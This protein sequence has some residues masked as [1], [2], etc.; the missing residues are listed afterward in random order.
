M[1]RPMAERGGL[2]FQVIVT[3]PGLAL[4][5]D[6]RRAKQMILN[7]LS[8]AIKFSQPGCRVELSA[9]R[10]PDKA[11]VIAVAD[12]GIGMSEDQVALALEAFGRV[13][14][15]AASDPTGTGLGLPIV[16]NLIEAHG[17]KLQILSELNRGTIARLVFPAQL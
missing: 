13:E 11:T 12:T 17:G 8:N 6:R 3:A 10:T 7:L 4:T 15:S 2:G 16:K 5:A 14:G 1:M 9:H